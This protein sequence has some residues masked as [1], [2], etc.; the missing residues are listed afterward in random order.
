MSGIAP[1]PNE[2][3]HCSELPLW[4]DS[5]EKV[6]F[7][8]ALC[9]WVVFQPLDWRRPLPEPDPVRQS[10]LAEVDERPGLDGHSQALSPRQ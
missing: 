6:G 4:A 8:L 1:I 3:L 10:A 2:P 7:R 9:S 5:V